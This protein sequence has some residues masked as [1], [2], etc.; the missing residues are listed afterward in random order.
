M[1]AKVRNDYL[2]AKH[3]TEFIKQGHKESVLQASSSNTLS[4][5]LMANKGASFT[6]LE[7]YERPVP[8]SAVSLRRRN[9]SEAQLQANESVPSEAKERLP[10]VKLPTDN[11]SLISGQ[12]NYNAMH[13]PFRFVSVE[14]NQQLSYL[15]TLKHGI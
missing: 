9:A 1:P 6:K 13:D 5:K 4:R 12:G 10:S 11:A 2:G 7:D 14:Q 15:A 8:L 3:I